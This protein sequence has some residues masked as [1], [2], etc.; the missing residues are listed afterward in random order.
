[1]DLALMMT[2]A[3]QATEEGVTNWPAAI[4]GATA[5]A[6]GVLMITSIVTVALWQGLGTWR[7]R[8]TISREQAY[9]KL[10]E[11]MAET[12][13]ATRTNLEQMTQEVTELRQRTA[14]MERMM[15]EV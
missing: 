5:I 13:R 1:M 7:A 4:V 14:E 10:A 6:A 11:E 3:M 12:Q 9:Q 15:K 2:V 8:M